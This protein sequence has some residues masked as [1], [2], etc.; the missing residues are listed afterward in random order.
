MYPFKMAPWAAFAT[1][2]GP[3]NIVEL[4]PSCT[5]WWGR[6]CALHYIGLMEQ[7]STVVSATDQ[8]ASDTTVDNDLFGECLVEEGVDY[9]EL[10]DGK[11]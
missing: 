2:F 11:S 8:E 10:D 6:G 7:T 1:M 5:D 9:I 3:K 4:P